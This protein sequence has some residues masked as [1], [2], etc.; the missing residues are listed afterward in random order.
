MMIRSETPLS[1]L[2][3]RS[4][5]SIIINFEELFEDDMFMNQEEIDMFAN[6]EPQHSNGF[7]RRI[8]ES[9][10]L[11]AVSLCETHQLFQIANH[12]IKDISEFQYDEKLDSTLIEKQNQLIINLEPQPESNFF[13][14]SSIKQFFESLRFEHQDF[15][16]KI[17]NIIE[18]NDPLL[19]I[20]HRNEFLSIFNTILLHQSLYQVEFGNMLRIINFLS[21][22]PDIKFNVRDASTAASIISDTHDIEVNRFLMMISNALRCNY[23]VET[24]RIALCDYLRVFS[25]NRIMILR[26]ILMNIVEDQIITSDSKNCIKSVLKLP[27]PFVKKNDFFDEI[28]NSPTVCIQKARELSLTI[29]E[30]LRDFSSVPTIVG[31]ISYYLSLSKDFNSILLNTEKS[32]IKESKKIMSSY[33]SINKFVPASSTLSPDLSNNISEL[34]GCLSLLS[35]YTSHTKL[36]ILTRYQVFLYLKAAFND[37]YCSTQSY[38][39][40]YEKSAQSVLLYSVITLGSVINNINIPTIELVKMFPK[41]DGLIKRCFDESTRCVLSVLKFQIENIDL[42]HSSIHQIILV[43]QQLIA[44]IH[45]SLERNMSKLSQ[46]CH[47]FCTQ[48]IEYTKLMHDAIS[49]LLGYNNIDEIEKMM[50]DMIKSLDILLKYKTMMFI[51]S[52]SLVLEQCFDEFTYIVNKHK[53]I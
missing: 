48:W 11:P 2:M 9:R 50:N 46:D 22:F 18:S 40:P 24:V 17:N 3:D 25:D 38:H 42:E 32:L 47:Q 34:L 41:V 29:S 21:I 39:S 44:N 35:D 8:T 15:K 10:S 6:D 31:W 30:K 33:S 5:S 4:E 19:L 14:F 26:W 23:I 49:N 1:P 20:Y 16:A 28:D 7:D 53:N 45:S 51:T 36:C 27:Y 13:V 12:F 37:I 52:E 43:I